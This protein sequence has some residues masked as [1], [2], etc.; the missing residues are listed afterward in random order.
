MRVDVSG[1]LTSDEL[2]RRAMR[3]AMSKPSSTRSTTRSASVTSSVT[4]GCWA[5]NSTHSGARCSRP[6]EKGTLMRNRPLASPLR[7]VISASASST[8]PSS[9]RQRAWKTSPSG[10]SE[11]LRVVR[12]S[13]RTPSRDSSSAT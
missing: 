7:E 6:K 11:S 10:V 2:G 12:C 4:F 13:S 5:M 8:P 9:S 3:T 1:R